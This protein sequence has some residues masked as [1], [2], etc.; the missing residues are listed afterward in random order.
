MFDPHVSPDGETVAI[1]W[2]RNDR[3]QGES[4]GG[5]WLVS[6]TDDSQRRV[7]AFRKGDA[8]LPW[9]IGWTRDGDEILVQRGREIL[10]VSKQ[11]GE[12]VLVL[13]LPEDADYCT[14]IPSGAMDEFVCEKVEGNVNVWL[15]EDFDLQ[16]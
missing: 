16:E 13:T 11:G 1:T 15:V 8:D 12:P 7:L 14:P 2:N 4:L 10:R 6:L 5:V 9:P 3:S